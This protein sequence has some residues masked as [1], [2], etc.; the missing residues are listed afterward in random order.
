LQKQLKDRPG[1][2]VRGLGLV[3]DA[4]LDPVRWPEAI[5]SL[6]DALM[7]GAAAVLHTPVGFLVDRYNARRFLI[8]G[9]PRWGWITSRAARSACHWHAWPLSRPPRGWR[10]T[11]RR[12][13]WPA[14]PERHGLHG[15]PPLTLWMTL[16]ARSCTHAVRHRVG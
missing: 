2:F 9:A 11:G 14:G 7:S 4:A 16:W 12:D 15:V 13:G 5:N 10:A 6:T 8:G 3:F 1:A